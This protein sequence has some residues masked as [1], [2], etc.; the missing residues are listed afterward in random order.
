[1]PTAS[2]EVVV[3]IVEVDMEVDKEADNDL[4]DVTLV[5]DDTRLLKTLLSDS[6]NSEE[7]LQLVIPK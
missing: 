4:T 7:W 3:V 5:S 1:M 2:L 6:G